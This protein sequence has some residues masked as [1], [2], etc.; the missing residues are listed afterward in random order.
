MSVFNNEQPVQN[1]VGGQQHVRGSIN[2]GPVQHNAYYTH[3]EKYR[4]A[5]SSGKLNG[6]RNTSYGSCLTIEQT[7]T[8]WQY[9][10]MVSIT[11]VV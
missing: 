6:R 9:T 11:Y 8:H 10:I 3:A 5:D 1:L 7:Q 2:Y 4:L